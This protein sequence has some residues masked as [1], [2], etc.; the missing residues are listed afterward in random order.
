MSGTDYQFEWESGSDD[1][2][3]ERLST[4]MDVLDRKIG[5]GIPPGR[6]V[7]LLASPAS[8]SELFLY[9]LAAVRDTVYLTTERTTADVEAT[10]EENDVST[11][12]VDVYRLSVE[13]PIDDARAAIDGVAE[14]STVIVDPVGP[15]E[16]ADDREY[17]SLLNHLK[18]RTRETGS[19]AMLHCLDGRDVP[20]QR[21][22]TEYL[23]D[24]I[25]DLSTRLRGGS[26]E[27]SLSIPKFRGGRSLPESIELDLT[28]DVTI[29][30]SRKIA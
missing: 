8:Q 7:A 25:F 29:D 26:V 17:R 23:V 1:E 21:D 2:S 10:L 19:L 11:E 5:G 18:E 13:N 27:N 4:G 24:V 14:E 22:R 15:L 12:R 3:G 16:T 9:E 20:T 6:V 28:T 30:V